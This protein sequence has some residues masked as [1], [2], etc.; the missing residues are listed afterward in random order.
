VTERTFSGTYDGLLK[1]MRCM[2]Y[3]TPHAVFAMA[4]R[5]LQWISRAL[6]PARMRLTFFSFTPPP[7]ITVMRSPAW[8]P[9]ESMGAHLD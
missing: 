2:S 1:R 8:H 3:A 9:Q 7:G 4:A 6:H 5:A